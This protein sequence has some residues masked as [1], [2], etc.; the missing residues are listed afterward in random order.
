M[1]GGLRGGRCGDAVGGHGESQG[2]GQGKGET[3]G[4]ESGSKVRTAEANP[5]GPDRRVT[6]GMAARSSCS[7][8]A[9][10]AG[11][12]G[13]ARSAG[14]RQCTRALPLAGAAGPRLARRCVTVKCLSQTLRRGAPSVLVQRW[15]AWVS[16]ALWGRLGFHL[17][18]QQ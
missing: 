13:R 8:S 10:V 2:S 5:A 18:R 1:G 16:F 14:R 12:R 9:N 6:K 11:G 3:G 4:Q 17:R 7:Q 15:L